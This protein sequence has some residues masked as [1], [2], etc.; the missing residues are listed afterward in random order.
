MRE[1]ELIL[2]YGYSTGILSRSS[3]LHLSFISALEVVQDGDRK[4][5]KFA[6]F[7]LWDGTLGSVMLYKGYCLV[8][9]F[10]I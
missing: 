3:R 4:C 5:A 8:V 10:N 9:V 2:I 7:Y 1:R 6:L